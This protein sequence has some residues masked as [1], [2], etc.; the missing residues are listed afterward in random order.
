MP[1]LA[2]TN[3]VCLS[4]IEALLLYIGQNVAEMQTGVGGK[5]HV[6]AEML[7]VSWRFHGT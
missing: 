6:P 5:G 2:L 1:N 3:N 7:A 4:T